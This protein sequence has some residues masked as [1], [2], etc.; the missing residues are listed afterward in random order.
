MVPSFGWDTMIH[1]RRDPLPEP[2]TLICVGGNSSVRQTPGVEH[3]RHKGL[4]NRAENSHRPTRRQVP[5]GDPFPLGR[6]P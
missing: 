4:N 5:R 3:R 2:A 1:Q 6:R